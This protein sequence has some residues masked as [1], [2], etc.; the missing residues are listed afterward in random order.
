MKTLSTVVVLADA[1][2]EHIVGGAELTLGALIDAVPTDV[3]VVKLLGREV[4][5]S[6]VHR[7][8]DALWIVGNYATVPKSVLVEIANLT[9]YVFVE[10]DYKYCSH[11]SSHLHTHTTGQA[12]S[13]HTTEFGAFARGFIRRSMLTFF[14]SKEQM[15]EYTRLFPSLN[16]GNLRVQGSTWRVSELDR[17]EEVR[18]STQE[19]SDTWMVLGGGSWIKNQ[20]NTEA[21]LKALGRPYKVFGGQV[22]YNDFV[23]EMA[24]HKGLCFHP[25]GF[26]T[27]P[28][29][30]IEAALL[31]LEIDIN[32]F[33]QHKT[34]KWWI[35]CVSNPKKLRK[36]L[37]NR[38]GYFWSEIVKELEK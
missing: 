21:G 20:D 18:K 28:R 19:K 11:R 15:G 38:P 30:V 7:Y 24:K 36:Y 26:D 29:I 37:A 14:M 31:G 1:Y 2:E 13:C 35:D 3:K 34:E 27:C 23:K 12:C 32:D 5:L 10:F 33:V 9:R 16:R 8:Q 6:H 22:P 25:A 17:L 4:Q